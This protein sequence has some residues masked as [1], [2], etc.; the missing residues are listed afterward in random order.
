M[1]IKTKISYYK[2][3]ILCRLWD[4]TLQVENYDPTDRM[5]NKEYK[6]TKSVLAKVFKKLLKKHIDKEQ[7]NKFTISFEYYE[8]YFLLRFINLMYSYLHPTDQVAM[9]A[10]IMELDQKL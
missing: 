9:S 10:F 2:L 3:D 1:K 8:A 5:L 6:A 4:L 7:G